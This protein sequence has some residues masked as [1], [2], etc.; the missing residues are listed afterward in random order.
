MFEQMTNLPPSA[1]QKPG[2]RPPDLSMDP[3]PDGFERADRSLS[4]QADI[5][6]MLPPF[7]YILGVF[8]GG[9]KDLGLAVWLWLAVSLLWTP[10]ITF[11]VAM[12]TPKGDPNAALAVL[13]IGLWPWLIF[14][15]AVD[16]ASTRT[17]LIV[18]FPLIFLFGAATMIAAN[19]DWPRTKTPGGRSTLLMVG[20]TVFGL[21]AVLF[22]A[23]LVLG[24][25][26]AA[27]ILTPAIVVIGGAAAIMAL[28]LAAE[29]TRPA[30]SPPG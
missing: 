30:S 28:A 29:A 26:E 2:R 16:W 21:Y 9:T 3:D 1:G 8:D 18:T 11:R 6:V 25:A 4:N 10:W 15:F 14:L 19:F 20:A 12:R 5:M 7:I 13:G 17:G 22:L 23:A 24:V 27:G